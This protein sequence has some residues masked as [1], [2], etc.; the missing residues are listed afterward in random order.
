N[1]L[2]LKDAKLN[3]TTYTYDNLDHVATRKDALLRTESYT[4]DPNGN[5]LTATDRKGQ[6]TEFRWDNLDRQSFAGFGRTGTAPNYSYQS[7]IAYTYDTANRLHI[8]TD[9]ASGTA[10]REYDT[11]D[12]LTSETTAQGVVTYQFDAAGRRAQLQ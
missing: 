8:A 5:L 2:T 3:T 9:S 12:R 1:R 10:T 7:T 6:V 11:L 4:Y